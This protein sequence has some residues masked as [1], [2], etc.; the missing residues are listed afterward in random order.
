VGES[1]CTAQGLSGRMTTGPGPVHATVS[2]AG[3]VVLGHRDCPKPNNSFQ[4][5]FSED[6]K[7]PLHGMEIEEGR[8]RNCAFLEAS[9]WAGAGERTTVNCAKKLY[10]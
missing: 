6:F 8:K 1:L 10:V 7:A 3:R 2:S 4:G 9:L 5:A